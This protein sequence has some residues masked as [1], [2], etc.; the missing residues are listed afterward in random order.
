[1]KFILVATACASLVLG[2]TACHTWA[3][4]DGTTEAVANA[5]S[6]PIRVTRTDH[7]VIELDHASIANDSLIGYTT[8]KSHARV[9]FPVADV[10]SVSTREVSPARTAGLAAGT[11]VGLLALAGLLVGIAF[12]QVWGNSN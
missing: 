9:A 1:M 10:T 11:V 3:R 12:A 5:G 2:G 4:Q 7:S 8:D 6:S